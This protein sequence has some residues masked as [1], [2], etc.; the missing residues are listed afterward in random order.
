MHDNRRDK[1]F[2]VLARNGSRYSIHRIRQVVRT[3]LEFV[4]GPITT[5]CN[6]ALTNKVERRPTAVDPNR[7]RTCA[8]AQ[9]DTLHTHKLTP[10]KA[11]RPFK[12]INDIPVRRIWTSYNRRRRAK[13]EVGMG[14]GASPWYTKSCIRLV[15]GRFPCPTAPSQARVFAR[16]YRL[17]VPV[18]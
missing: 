6:L 10:T 18:R 14:A 17:P 8:G 1:I 12:P 13:R 15:P 7:E 5:P 3:R 16:Y 11:G 9:S 2:E 4:P